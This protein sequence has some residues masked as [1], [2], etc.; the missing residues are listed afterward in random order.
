MIA[1]YHRH[2]I[3]SAIYEVTLSAQVTI[4]HQRN[5]FFVPTVT[6]PSAGGPKFKGKSA[7]STVLQLMGSFLLLYVPYYSA[8]LWEAAAGTLQNSSEPPSTAKIDPNVLMVTSILLT[9]S[10]FVNGFFY[11]VKN[12][13]LRK[14]FRNYWRKKLTKSEV[15]QEIQ[16]RTPSTCGSR[17]PSLTPLGFFTKPML[18]RRLS[19]ALLDVHRM[20]GSPQRPKMKRIASELAWRPASTPGLNLSPTDEG[21]KKRIPHTASCN[22]LQVPKGDLDEVCTIIDDEITR[23]S[24]LERLR[25]SLVGA[26]LFFQR[27][28]GFEAVELSS[29]KKAAVQTVLNT[30]PKR[31]PQILITRAF[32]E[33]SDKTSSAPAS[34]SRDVLSRKL[35]SSTTT[36][37][38]RKWRRFR[39]R[40]EDSDTESRQLSTTKQPLLSSVDR[41]SSTSNRSSESSDTSEISTGRIYMALDSC[42][43]DSSA[44]EE[45]ILLSWRES[46]AFDDD[47][48]DDDDVVHAKK[49]SLLKQSLV[50]E[51]LVL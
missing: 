48:E 2:R 6:A 19:E 31:S 24:S 50:N 3:A 8:I 45:Q 11:G 12:K 28:F 7:I 42:Q 37:I 10:P 9:C 23:K 47:E 17:R 49:T 44:T 27:V 39:Y 18:T 21:Y 5:P 15:N 22:T 32:S 26:N 13:T 14:T 43:G 33:E 36:I 4:T 34:P 29:K 46:K 1:R 16:A 41:D 20:G 40:E 25:P 51:E 30:S 35:S 38:E